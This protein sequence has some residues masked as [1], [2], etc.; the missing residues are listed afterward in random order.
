MSQEAAATEPTES[1]EVDGGN[2]DVLLTPPEPEQAAEPVDTTPVDNGEPVEGAELRPEPKLDG[3]DAPADDPFRPGAEEKPEWVPEQFWNKDEGRLETQK[4]AK[5][6]EDLRAHMNR[7]EIGAPDD[8]KLEL[9]ESISELTEDDVAVFKEANLTNDQAQK[10]VDYVNETLFPVVQEAVAEGQKNLLAQKWN[11]DPTN[12][13]F[14]ERMTRLRDWAY[15]NYPEDLVK[16]MSRDAE[17]VNKL[18]AM[19]RSDSKS[20]VKGPQT[21][22]QRLSKAELDSKV[23]D[24]RYW[25]DDAFRAQVERE[26]GMK[27]QG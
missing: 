23:N 27:T 3:E 6:Y 4:L 1:A 20:D 19:M 10:M 5:S 17:G 11:M 14:Q 2:E 16:H 18:F 24:P 15:Q 26:L 7:Q 8:Y 12:E 13:M 21:A 25:T 22:Q 9:P